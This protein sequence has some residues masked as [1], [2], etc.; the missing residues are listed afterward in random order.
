M[1]SVWTNQLTWMALIGKFSTVTIVDPIYPSLVY[2]GPVGTGHEPSWLVSFKKL[3]L[4]NFRLIYHVSSPDN[5]IKINFEPWCF[6]RSYYFLFLPFSLFPFL[7][8]ED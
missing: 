1:V 4:V 3:T 5:L 7:Y 6:H 2:S 8:I